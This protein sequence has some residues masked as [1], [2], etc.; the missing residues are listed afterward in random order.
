VS[1][2]H[3]RLGSPADIALNPLIYAYTS[4]ILSYS[5][6]AKGM[7]LFLFTGDWQAIITRYVSRPSVT[8]L[9]SVQPYRSC[10]PRLE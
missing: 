3:R 4:E 5:T 1:H 2:A 10:E 9:T 7:S 8:Q 6:R